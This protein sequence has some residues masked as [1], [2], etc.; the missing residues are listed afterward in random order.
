MSGNGRGSQL[1]I[2]VRMAL[3]GGPIGG[4]PPGGVR[5]LR[6]GLG[7]SGIVFPEAA[8]MM[9]ARIVAA[10]LIAVML[11]WG[12]AHAPTKT[13]SEATPSPATGVIAGTVTDEHGVAIQ[14]GDVTIRGLN[15]WARTDAGG[16][17]LFPKMPVGNYAV[18]H[19]IPGF[20]RLKRDSVHVTEHDT[21]IVNFRLQ[22]NPIHIPDGGFE[23]VH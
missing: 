19:K 12:C 2:A 18:Y 22:A 8:R 11:F 23:V 15:I 5:N 6:G 17:Y 7:S 21:T 10:L 14:R 20:V 13:P 3:L 9:P 16:N 1:Y 4:D